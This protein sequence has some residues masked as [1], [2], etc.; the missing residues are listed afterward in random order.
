[1][2]GQHPPDEDRSRRLYTAAQHPAD[3]GSRD[4][5]PMFPAIID[6]PSADDLA[7]F[8]SVL[9]D[10]DW[11]SARFW[12]LYQVSDPQHRAALALAAP[13]HAAAFDRWQATGDAMMAG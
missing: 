10:G 3:G 6:P 4:A 1:M 7:H 12:R 8:D 13:E 9:P 5:G 11:W 2:S